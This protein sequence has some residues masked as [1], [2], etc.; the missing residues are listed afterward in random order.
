M[1]AIQP[2]INEATRLW[3]F[4]VFFSA[5]ALITKRASLRGDLRKASPEIRTNI[6]IFVVDALLVRPFI[7]VPVVGLFAAIG[8]TGF[9]FWEELPILVVLLLAIAAGDYIGYWR[10]RL[11]HI[12]ILWP[13]HATHH[14][15]RSMNWFTL[16]RI[17]PLERLYTAIVDSAALA[18]LGFPLWAIVLNNLIRNAW[19]YFIH[20][21]LRWTLGPIGLVMI[22]PSA[23]R[24]HHVRDFD[25]CGKNFATV[26]TAWD[27]L[28]GTYR[29]S[30]NPCDEP[31]GVEGHEGGYIYEML[32]PIRI[33]VG[34]IR[35]KIARV[36]HGPSEG[37]G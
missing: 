23:H 24:W 16:S 14:S 28:H 12:P 19:G 10:H 36:Y 1:E 5:L 35:R 27:R 13:F 37:S 20:A 29:H 11:N 4:A 17:H 21:D 22:S 26:F 34:M 32:S 8:W 15:D 18:L 9:G 25:E 3:P 31:T 30:E 7:A 6:T 33:W 2:L